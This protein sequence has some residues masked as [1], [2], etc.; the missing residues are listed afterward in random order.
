MDLQ[1][2]TEHTILADSAERFLSENYDFSARHGDTGDGDAWQDDMWGRFAELGWLALPFAEDDGGLGAG[3]VEISI[4]AEAFGRNLVTEPYM[5]TVV[6]CGSLVDA[7]GTKEQR[8]EILPAIGEGTLRLA[9]MGGSDDIS[10]EAK[11][12]GDG[13]ILSGA[14]KSVI[15]APMA[16]RLLWSRSPPQPNTSIKRCAPASRNAVNAASRLSGECA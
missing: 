5:T 7:I 16:G 4:L 8:A 1:L 14:R 3:M 9:Y 13:Y 2:D 10:V 15:D 11:T 12:N 6:L